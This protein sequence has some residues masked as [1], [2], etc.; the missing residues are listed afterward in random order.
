MSEKKLS[1]PPGTKIPNHIAIIP[2][3][4]RRWAKDRH[5]P[6]LE[7]H[8]CGA[9]VTT[10]IARAARDFGVHTLTFWGFST[11]NWGRSES[12]VSGLM[13]IFE[14]FI[15]QHLKEAQNDNVRIVHL[16]RKDR[17]PKTLARK[18]AKA[19]EET[20]NNSQHVFNIAIDY[21]GQDELL[22]AFEK[23]FRDVETGKIVLEKLS[24]EVGKYQGKYPYYYFKD[25]LD[26]AGQSHPYPDLVIR[27]SGERRL[28]G[29]IP[30]Q[31][32]Y[33]EIYWERDHFP[34]FTPEKLKQA[35]L[36]F[37]HR[38]RRFGGTNET[39]AGCGADG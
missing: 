39:R 13:K 3:G 33:S 37:G 10:K 1:L 20:K 2:D 9:K 4:N 18:L 29:F 36:D 25:Y 38:R 16:G 23:A 6:A 35:I 32:V 5:L 15:G 24:E 17:I 34:D 22:R 21:G 31:A 30:W 7:G 11:E 19:E 12:E 14:S 8:R 27:T 28:S 26:T